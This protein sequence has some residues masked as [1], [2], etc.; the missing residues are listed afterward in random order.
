M[1]CVVRV[2]LEK[3][4]DGVGYITGTSGLDFAGNPEFCRNVYHCEIGAIH[5]IML[6]L[7]SKFLSKL[8]SFRRI[9]M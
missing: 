3:I 1:L 5:R 8:V 7:V 2:N 9:L 4:F 6:I